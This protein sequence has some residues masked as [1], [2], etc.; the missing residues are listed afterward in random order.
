MHHGVYARIG[1]GIVAALLG[2]T[3]TAA[4]AQG[5]D[6]GSA[7]A[8]PSTDPAKT[9]AAPATP[10][11]TAPNGQT[12]AQ[13]LG[14]IIVT[15]QRRSENLQRVP[16]AVTAIGSAQLAKTQT[17]TTRDVQFSTPSLVYNQAANNAQPFLRGIGSDLFGP[18]LDA[19]VA[20]YVDGVYI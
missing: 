11:D 15:A 5:Q 9:D 20:T 8:P 10:Q 17:L 2:T 3:S 19:S 14:D 7:T 16:I 12:A 13:P 6:K 4:L 18:N 1:A